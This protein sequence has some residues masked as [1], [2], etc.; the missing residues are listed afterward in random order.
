MVRWV[1]RP[2][3]RWQEKA[4]FRGQQSRWVYQHGLGEM[5]YNG[6]RQ[7]AASQRAS[8]TSMPVLSSLWDTQGR[9]P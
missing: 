9:S 4:S 2:G 8:E 1:H 5:I 3:A 7:W 6:T